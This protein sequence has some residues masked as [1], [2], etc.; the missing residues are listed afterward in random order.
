MA[1]TPPPQKNRR[2]RYEDKVKYILE[3]QESKSCSKEL[4]LPTEEESP[5]LE[6]GLQPRTETDEDIPSCRD[7]KDT[8]GPHDLTGL[9][10][11]DTDFPSGEHSE[12]VDRPVTESVTT[13]PGIDTDVISDEHSELVD[14]PVTESVTARDGSDTDFPSS[15]HSELVDRPVTESVTTWTGIDTD[16]PSDEHSELVNR[17]VT[18]SV[19]ARDGS[20]TDFSKSYYWPNNVPIVFLDLANI[21]LYTNFTSL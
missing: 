20:D 1:Y 21:G 10:G 4:G 11:S 13:W 15:E 3:V 17:P 19:T 12:L 14:R 2:R 7:K 16:F 9:T 6:S 8:Y 5:Q 18:E